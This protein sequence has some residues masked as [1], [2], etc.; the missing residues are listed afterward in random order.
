MRFT[1]A[2]KPER[3]E[4]VR[5]P[6]RP[7]FS[8]VTPAQLAHI[9]AVRDAAKARAI[10]K[11]RAKPRVARTPVK[12]RNERA[13]AR[14]HANYRSVIASDFNKQLRYKTF[15]RSGGLCECDECV[16]IRTDPSE[17]LVM[18]P[19][20]IALAFAE[21]P[22]W[23]TKK[24]GEPWRRFRSND[25]ELHHLNY[26]YFGDENPD[27]LRFVRWVWTSCHQRI[28]AEHG[29]RRRYLSGRKLPCLI[30]FPPPSNCQTNPS[31]PTLSG[32]AICLAGG[33]RSLRTCAP[34]TT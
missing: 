16:A 30:L 23:F 32:A 10:A 12:Q 14:R 13:I 17:R 29:T 8:A 1:P 24:G 6:L 19:E 9:K 27:E 15:V 22:V 31:G 33:T 25:G 11:A 34:R 5:K 2:P 20:R 7:S 28:E 18:F 26:K 4:K 3:A 21:I